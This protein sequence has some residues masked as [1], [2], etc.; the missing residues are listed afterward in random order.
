[1]AGQPSQLALVVKVDPIDAGICPTFQEAW[2]GTWRCPWCGGGQGLGH[3][4]RPN[5]GGYAQ[6][7][8]KW[9]G[10]EKERG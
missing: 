5:E 10:C 8:E 1:M 7:D 9:Q 4:G 6:A 3:A 2:S